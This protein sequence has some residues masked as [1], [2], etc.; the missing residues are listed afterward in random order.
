MSA[1]GTVAASIAVA[2]L[3][4]LSR[5]R[6]VETAHLAELFGQG[7]LGGVASILG[8]GVELRRRPGV[9]P[10]GQVEHRAWT[11]G[12]LFLVRAGPAIA[13]PRILGSRS[14]LARIMR[15]SD[16]LDDLLRRPSAD[17]LLGLSE[18]FTDRLH[19]G[20]PSFRR[21]VRAL[22]RT[23]SWAAQAMFG[24]ALF[25]VPRTAAARERI[26][27]TLAERDLPALEARVAHGGARRLAASVGE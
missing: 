12:T 7:G 14:W 18:Q 5:R 26:L 16:G 20:S 9:P 2:S 25:V 3:A 10:W 13:S 8:G 19:L 4:G 6:A 22:R 15:A 11:R 24:N 27:E 17:G 23:G 1:S 21:T